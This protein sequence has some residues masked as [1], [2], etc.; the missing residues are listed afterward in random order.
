[1]KNKPGEGSELLQHI[2][3]YAKENKYTRLS[4][5]ALNEEKLLSW[6]LCHGF[7][8]IETIF[9]GTQIKAIKLAID[10]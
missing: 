9:E 5:H 3:E 8:I 4:L 10:L 6:Y 7:K 1:M 2:I